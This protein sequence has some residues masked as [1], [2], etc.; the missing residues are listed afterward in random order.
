MRLKKHADHTPPRRLT[1]AEQSDAIIRLF[2]DRHLMEDVLRRSHQAV[3]ARHQKW[4]VPLIVW[5]DGRVQS[6]DPHTFPKQK[7]PEGFGPY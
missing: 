4:N 6:L 1:Q 3:I 2:S 7:L 5:R